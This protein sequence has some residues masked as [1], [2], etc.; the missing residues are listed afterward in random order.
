M[1]D[2]G[3]SLW[4]WRTGDQWLADLTRLA[5]DWSRNIKA[6][7]G[8]GQGSFTVADLSP[9]E[10][11]FWY[12]S[13]LGCVVR[14]YTGSMLSWEGMIVEMRLIKSGIE[15]L[16]ALTPDR[17]HNK[18]KVMYT[19]ANNA[20]QTLAWSENADS[21][22]E[23]GEMQ[24]IE[25]AGA[26]AATPMGYLQ[27]RHLKEF[28]WPRSWM[29]GPVQAGGEPA[30]GGDALRV[31]VAGFWNTLNWRYYESTT[32]AQAAA[33]LG[34]LVAASEWVTAGRIEA[35]AM[36][37]HIN[38]DT[39]QRIGGLVEQIISQGDSSGNVWRGGVYADRKMIYE[40]VPTT[41]GY[42]MRNRRLT[43]A[44]DTDIIPTLMLPGGLLLN[45]DAPVGRTPP[46]SLSVWDNPRVGYV[47][48]VEFAAPDKLSLKLRGQEESLAILM[49]QHGGA[50]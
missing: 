36:S 42:N 22:D 13:Y 6:I 4:S 3:L 20:Q 7:G 49:A 14:E 50:Q 21:S 44:A 28:A 47:E 43:D 18:V 19:D 16:R 31:T 17:W 2:Y 41:I 39:P 24:W 37:V 8:Y 38:C 32:T 25:T 40:Q 5:P 46:G 9:A 33:L 29:I 27:A 34:T 48:E 26:G 15:Y 12:D 35:N 30:T 11:E 45:A 1:S 10:L 23:F